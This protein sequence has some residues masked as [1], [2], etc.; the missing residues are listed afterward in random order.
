MEISDLTLYPSPKK[1]R[2]YFIIIKHSFFHFNFLP[3]LKVIIITNRLPMH[4][5]E[6]VQV[7][8]TTLLRRI[9]HTGLKKIIALFSLHPFV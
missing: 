6:S 8:D 9:T 7:S 3:D 5:E 4:K 2:R 1:E